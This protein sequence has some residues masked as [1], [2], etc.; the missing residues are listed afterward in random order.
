[1]V[2]S[3]S[4]STVFV[5]SPMKTLSEIK[6]F[7]NYLELSPSIFTEQKQDRIQLQTAGQHRKGHH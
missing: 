4:Y 7:F 2:T 5:L 3:L 1:M 6:T